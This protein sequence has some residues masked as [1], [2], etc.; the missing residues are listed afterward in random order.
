MSFVLIGGK[1]NIERLNIIEKHIVKMTKKEKPVFL[2]CPYAVTD[3]EKSINKFHELMKG[4]DCQIIDLDFN[5]INDFE[6]LL[7]SSDCLYIAGGSCDDLV[8]FFKENGL[9]K[10]IDK[11]IDSNIVFAGQSAGAMLWCKAAMGDK[12]MFSDNFHNYNYKM[13]NCLGY[14]DI[15]I[16]PHYQNED[17]IIYNDEIKKYDY[18]AFGIEEDTALIIDGNSFYVIKDK[19]FRSVYY[20]AKNDRIMRPLYEGEIYEKIGGFRSKG[21]L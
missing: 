18:D 7:K 20:F 3:I 16:C 17:L 9:D 19:S 2:F 11:Y 14:L 10:I 1:G 13:V 12:Y 5:N 8:T 21:N 4:I 6:N 15:N